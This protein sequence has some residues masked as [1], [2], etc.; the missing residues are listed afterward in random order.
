[1]V[2]FAPAGDG[3]TVSCVWIVLVRVDGI[4]VNVDDGEGDCAGFG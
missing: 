1:M 2:S 3:D 4:G